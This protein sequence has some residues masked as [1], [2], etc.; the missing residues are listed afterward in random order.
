LWDPLETQEVIPLANFIKDSVVDFLKQGGWNEKA[1]DIIIVNMWMNEM[2]TGANHPVHT[3]Y[4]YSLSGTY[5]VELPEEQ[6]MIMFHHHQQ[7]ESCPWI[8][9]VTAWMPHNSMT[10]WLPVE[11]GSLV[12]FPSNIKHSVPSRE[13][14][15][16]R[17][18]IAFD[19]ILRVKDTS[20]AT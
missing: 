18:S 14:K 7:G 3:H 4:G 8:E 6:D 12:L 9:E 5:Y 2:K 13:F 1:Y 16:L 19:I 20:Y 17:K 10:W 15:G 11:A